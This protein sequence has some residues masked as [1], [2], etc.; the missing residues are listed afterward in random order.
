MFRQKCKD[1]IDDYISEY[2]D[3][4]LKIS[5]TSEKVIAIVNSSL[6]RID[7]DTYNTI[8]C[9]LEE[10]ETI[11]ALLQR[12]FS[13]WHRITKSEWQD[14]ERNICESL[15]ILD[16]N[17]GKF[18]YFEKQLQ[19]M[20]DEQCRW[21]KFKQEQSVNRMHRAKTTEISLFA[22]CKTKREFSKRYRLLVKKYHPDNGGS[23][24]MFQK[25]KT[26]YEKYMQGVK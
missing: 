12:Q 25:V 14:Y 1:V 6:T 4:L 3:R 15:D 7:V 24:E 5:G 8:K 11:L 9:L 16:G 22:G 21:S 18:L 20:I 2:N 13:S 26:E 19:N 10:T 17:Y 23:R